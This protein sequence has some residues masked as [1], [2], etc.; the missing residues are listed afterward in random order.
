MDVIN[1]LFL[2]SNLN[3]RNVLPNP[4]IS[5]QSTGRDLFFRNDT[6]S[7]YGNSP[8]TVKRRTFTNSTIFNNHI[9]PDRLSLNRKIIYS[10]STNGLNDSTESNR[11]S[12]YDSTE[13]L[14][15]SQPP[16]PIFDIINDSQLDNNDS[17]I[18]DQERKSQRSGSIYSEQQAVLSPG[19]KRK[20]FLSAK[21]LKPFQS[22]RSRKKSNN[23]NS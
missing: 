6:A 12:T 15:T 4:T 8:S 19:K 5:I 18:D 13:L 21:L 9:P 3:I 2:F 11:P 10:H 17:L 14:S 1:F 23:S 16:K 22:M 7:D 20:Q